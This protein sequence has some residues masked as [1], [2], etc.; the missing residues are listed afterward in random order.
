MWFELRICHSAIS[1]GTKFVVHS[2]A[3]LSTLVSTALVNAVVFLSFEL[4]F[5]PNYY[6]WT[7]HGEMSWGYRPIV[8]EGSVTRNVESNTYCES[9]FDMA[10]LDFEP[11]AAYYNNKDAPNPKAQRC[12]DMFKSVDTPLYEGCTKY[13]QLSTMARLLN[14]MSENNMS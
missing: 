12:Y 7:A 1:C 14:I 8:W 4:G 5:L 3:S 6:N 2:I 13:S 9:I 10:G 11:N